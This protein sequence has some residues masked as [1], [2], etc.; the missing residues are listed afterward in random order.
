MLKIC[1]TF[2][3]E[4]FLGENFLPE[5][6]VLFQPAAQLGEMLQ[7]EE[8]SATFFADVC[9]VM[10]H[11]IYNETAYCSNFSRQIAALYE[12]GHDVQLHIHPNWLN[13][14]FQNGKWTIAQKGYKLHEFGFD[15][16]AEH[17]AQEILHRGKMYLEETLQKVDPNYRCIAYRAGGFCIQPEEQL[18][19][20]LVDL[21][22]RIDSSVALKQV[23]RGGI[24]D[25]DF[26]CVPHALNWWMRPES[27]LSK[28]VTYGD[29]TV[30]E[31]AIGTA[32]NC[33]TK[34]VGVAK[35]A[36][37]VAGRGNAGTGIQMPGEQLGRLKRFMLML[38]RR[39]YSD[40]ILSLDTRGYGILLR[41]LDEIY[42]K[43]GCAKRD[44]EV[45][46]ICHP[47]LASQDTIQNMQRFV[48]E[49]KKQPEK[50]SFTTMQKI[51]KEHG[52]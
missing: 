42:Q 39:L 13:S 48:Q 16:H 43:Y 40:G 31:V 15:E 14:T 21:D 19:K 11:E 51:A 24:Q 25:Y 46:I 41:D 29:G 17:S 9:S 27:G 20:A 50:F 52:L 1:I 4:L 35:N 47:K 34:Y 22:I 26:S 2:D 32:R 18:L 28:A 8:V 3:Y 30:Y 6:E 7:K 45:A 36:L 38:K 37:H 10:Q 49:V 23:A 44:Q 33:L 12:M 5:E